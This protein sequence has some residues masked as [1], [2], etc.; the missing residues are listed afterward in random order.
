MWLVTP[1]V[2]SVI[3]QDQL[4]VMSHEIDVSEIAPVLS[5]IAQSCASTRGGPDPSTS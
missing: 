2:A 5:G 1:A 3:D 4:K